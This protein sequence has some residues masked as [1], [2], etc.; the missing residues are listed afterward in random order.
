MRAIADDLALAQSP[1][2]EE[3]LLV[4]IISQLGDEYNSI[5]AAI[6]VRETPLSYSELFDKLTDF[7]RGL[8]EA[9]SNIDLTI[10]T[11]N[12]TGQQGGRQVPN[13]FQRNSRPAQQRQQGSNRHRWSNNNPDNRSSRT[14]SFCHYCNIPGH[15]THDC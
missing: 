13:S 4:H 11:V 7:E 9:S 1:V 6:K 3:D 15:H 2:A 14:P 10:P 12:F 8:K 5:V